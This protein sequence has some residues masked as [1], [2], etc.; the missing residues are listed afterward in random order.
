MNYSI[1]IL[2]PEE[3]FSKDF[4]RLLPIS[5]IKFDTI[6]AITF[7][8]QFVGRIVMY[9][10]KKIII[11]KYNPETIQDF[12]IIIGHQPFESTK[13]MDMGRL[14]RSFKRFN[15]TFIM[16]SFIDI[17]ENFSSFIDKQTIFIPSILASISDSILETIQKNQDIQINELTI[18]SYH[19][20]SNFGNF[21]VDAIYKQSRVFFEGAIIE[22]KKDQENYN[23]ILI[24][25][26]IAFNFM[27][28]VGLKKFNSLNN[29][30]LSLL[31]YATERDFRILNNKEDIL[32]NVNASQ[33]PCFRGDG[34]FITFNF[35][36]KFSKN[37]II[38]AISNTEG[39]IFEEDFSYILGNKKYMQSV[40]FYLSRLKFFDKSIS[41]YINY[42]NI[43]YNANQ[44]INILE[45]NFND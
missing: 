29:N 21:G 23:H 31:E 25:N 26:D 22:E 32:I 14:E 6:S 3:I 15:G 8:E 44:F 5:G 36:N 30:D 12:D 18:N 33:A 9:G 1:A 40:D 45:Q 20:F 37:L 34:A 11:E 39:L 7:D 13:K 42:D 10:E 16:N 19:S 41:F 4:L 2:N 38:E 43:T 17:N 28:F 35:E 27:P 24:K